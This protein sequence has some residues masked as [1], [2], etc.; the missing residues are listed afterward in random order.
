MDMQP[1]VLF[2][3]QI[4]VIPIPIPVPGLGLVKILVK[5]LGL[6][7]LLLKVEPSQL[8]LIER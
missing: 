6:K 2:F 4:S 7:K 1:E 8:S 5:I 3:H